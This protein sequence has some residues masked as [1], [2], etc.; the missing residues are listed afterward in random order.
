MPTGASSRPPS[1]ANLPGLDY[2][3]GAVRR[4]AAV[5]VVPLDSEWRVGAAELAQSLGMM[6]MTHVADPDTWFKTKYADA[7]K[8]RAKPE[9]YKPL[10]KMLDRFSAP[11]IGAHMG[12]WP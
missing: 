5:H 12:G 3:A 10:E 7:S 2:R 4:P 9:H 6:F 8:Y 11:W 1:A